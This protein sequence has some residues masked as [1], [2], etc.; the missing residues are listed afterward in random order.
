MN[1]VLKSSYFILKVGYLSTE[2]LAMAEVRMVELL[3]QIRPDAVPLVDAFDFT[4]RSLCSIL[5][6]YDGNVY[7]NMYKWAKSSPLNKTEVR[8]LNNYIY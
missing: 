7:E 2:Q 4:D 6:R 5:G 1:I 8:Y 3:G